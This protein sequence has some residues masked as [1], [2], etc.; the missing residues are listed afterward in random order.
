MNAHIRRLILA[1]CGCLIVALGATPVAAHSGKQSYVYFSLFDDGVEGR[2]E[3]PAAD[4]AAMLGVEFPSDPADAAVVADRFTDEIR[5][6]TAD[7][8]T[9]GDGTSTWQI[10]LDAP[11]ILAVAGNYVVVP[12]RAD[13]SFDSAPRSFVVEF[14]GIIHANDQ[15]DALLIVENDWGSATFNNEDEPLAGFSVGR[16]VQDVQLTQ[17]PTLSSMAGAR[18]VG[19]DA[20][21][22]SIDQLLFVV[23]VVLPVGLVAH[24]STVRAPAPRVREA[25]RRL[26][27]LLV[28]YAI[29]QAATL[30]LVG[31]GVIDLPVRLTSTL[32][33]AALLVA[34][35]ATFWRS[36]AH[37]A[38]AVG[39][40]S[41]VMGLGLGATFTATGLD[42]VSPLA[43][44]GFNVGVLAGALVVVALTF[45]VLLVLRRTIAAPVV[46]YGTAAVIALYAVG[47]LIER[48]ASVDL[49]LERVANP[50]RVWPRNLW[51]MVAVLAAAGLLYWWTSASGRLRPLEGTTERASDGLGVADEELVS[52]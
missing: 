20:L 38:V 44:L 25:F 5:Q 27:G 9:A 19:T 22:T 40:L 35:L 29:G 11:E 39:A 21:R 1:V 46:L 23:A 32:A 7:H 2:I 17:A 50:L 13:E 42:R 43:L 28:A 34:S 48:G 18:G 24:G 49:D 26:A 45:P 12:F 51:V 30:W 41:S 31:L 14:D 52:R 8:F 37:E 16:T 15:K 10:E 33:A 3:Y 4:L 36:R 47:W 6:Y